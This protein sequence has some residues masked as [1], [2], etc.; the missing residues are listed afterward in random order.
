MQNTLE[1]IKEE[2]PIDFKHLQTYKDE[3]Y[4]IVREVMRP[5]ESRIYLGNFKFVQEVL[6][7]LEK[8]REVFSQYCE[9]LILRTLRLWMVDIRDSVMTLDKAKKCLENRRWFLVKLLEDH[10]DIDAVFVKYWDPIKNNDAHL[11]EVIKSY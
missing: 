1:N 4:R 6:P 10:I 7:G 3:L 5:E 8:Y 2:E 11:A 9:I